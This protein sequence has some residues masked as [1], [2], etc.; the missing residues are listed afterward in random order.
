[1]DR[2][3]A[4]EE[5]VERIPLEAVMR[6]LPS[7]RARYAEV[8]REV[9]GLLV[10]RRVVEWSRANPAPGLISQRVRCGRRDA[11]DHHEVGEL[12]PGPATQP[13]NSPVAEVRADGDGRFQS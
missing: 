7:R 4:G 8:C 12:A 10:D 2:M 13:G 1:M 3:F 5:L 6:F 11:R 9:V